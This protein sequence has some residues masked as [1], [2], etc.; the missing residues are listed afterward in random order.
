MKKKPGF[1][2]NSVCGENFLIA[3]GVENID[4]SSLVCLNESSTYL[5]KTI[6]DDEEFDAQ[7]LAD[8]LVKE[9]E[10]DDATALADAQNLID[11]MLE[12]GVIC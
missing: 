1:A 12:A 3:E 10:V 4:F 11:K 7:K 2:L 8:L 5:W 6:G 9:Y